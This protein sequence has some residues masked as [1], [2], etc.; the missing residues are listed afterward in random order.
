MIVI[1]NNP[2][3]NDYIDDLK[4]KGYIVIDKVLKDCPICNKE[5]I[6]ELRE[7]ITESIIRDIKVQYIEYYYTCELTDRDDNEYVS[8]QMMDAN[9]GRARNE[10]FSIC[11]RSK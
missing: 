6:T 8:M 4:N 1:K 9:I 10:Y 5:H 2:N 3:S 11:E 7:R